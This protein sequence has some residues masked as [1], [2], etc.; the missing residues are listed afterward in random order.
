MDEKG[1]MEVP[2]SSSAPAYK[3]VVKH[4]IIGNPLQMVA[5]PTHFFKVGAA[6][7]CMIL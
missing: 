2:L 5:V 7:C 6:Y 3:W 1:V 4:E